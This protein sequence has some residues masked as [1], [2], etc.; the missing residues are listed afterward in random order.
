MPS[1]F[2]ALPLVSFV[3]VYVLITFGNT[4]PFVSVNILYRFQQSDE[5]YARLTNFEHWQQ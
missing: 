1:H 4:V 2:E 3:C 5:K